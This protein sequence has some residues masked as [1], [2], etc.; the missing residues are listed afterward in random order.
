MQVV[1]CDHC[2]QLTHSSEI[3]FLPNG[4]GTMQRVCTKCY[5]ELRKIPIKKV[6]DSIPVKKVPYFCKR[7]RYNFKFNE[8]GVN[9]LSCP[10]CGKDDELRKVEEFDY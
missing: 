5:Q 6:E 1:R 9:K 3:R 2:K 8:L 4:L 10:G 7:C